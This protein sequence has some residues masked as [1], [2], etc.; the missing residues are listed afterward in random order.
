[1][2]KEKG[3]SGLQIIMVPCNQFCD[4]GEPQKE[5]SIKQ[6]LMRH[7]KFPVLGLC[8]VIGK[9]KHPIYEYFDR[10]AD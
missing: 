4:E 3:E 2:F 10:W 7:I 5:D 6:G 8:E 9:N 1:M